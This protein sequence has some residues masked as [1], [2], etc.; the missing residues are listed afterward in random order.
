MSL[1]NRFLALYCKLSSHYSQDYFH[2]N[3][4]SV[5][6]KSFKRMGHYIRQCHSTAP[7]SCLVLQIVELYLHIILK[8][9]SI[10]I[11]TKSFKRMGQHIC[12]CHSTTPFLPRIANCS[13]PSV[14]SG[15][16]SLHIIFLGHNGEQ[17]R[18]N[19]CR[20]FSERR[21]RWLFKLILRISP[22]AFT[23]SD[24]SLCFLPSPHSLHAFLPKLLSTVL[25]TDI[26]LK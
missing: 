21:K 11:L 16:L 15:H 23:G 17:E 22:P 5:T 4:N 12:Q 3:F 20:S 18:E 6:L 7:L 9:N 8:I 25:H 1:Y 19:K 2:F 13:H 14:A 10:S 24:Y 26:V